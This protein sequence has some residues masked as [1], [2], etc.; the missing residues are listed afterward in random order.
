M[1]IKMLT[2]AVVALASTG[3]FAQ[4]SVTMYGVADV[5]IE[6]LTHAGGDNSTVR[7]S[8]G[9]LSGSRWGLRGTEDL[10]GGLKGIFT[11]ESGINIDTG[12]GADSSRMFNRQAFVGLQKDGIGTLTLGR[13]QTLLYDFGLNYDPMAIATR[14]SIIGQD[15]AFASRAD[16]AIKYVGTFGGVTASALYSFRYNGQEVPGQTNR[17]AEYS[18]GLNYATGP[19]SVGAV[20]DQVRLGLTAGVADTGAKIQRASIA[21]TYAFGPAKVFGGWRWAN[22]TMADNH[23]RSN[24]WW[25]GLGYQVTPAL[26]LTGAVYYQAFHQTSADP[27]TLVASADYALSKRT[28]LYLN[29][30]YAINKKDNDRGIVSVV[31]VSNADQPIN[32]QNQFGAVVGIRHKF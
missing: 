3:A 28:D 25:T 8:S 16:N 17:G 21:G 29:M 26:S 6:Y 5:G 14:Y 7:M 22:Q 32:G 23:V 20:Y 24:L 9:N 13:Q 4:S 2:A 31:G 30:A 1:K 10:G 18:A 19:L 12:S 15:G 27:W 11:L